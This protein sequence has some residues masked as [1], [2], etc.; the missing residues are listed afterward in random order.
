MSG[1]SYD[2]PLRER[3]T[4][5]TRDAILDALT[6]A[7]NDRAVDEVTT[8]ELAASAGVSERTVYRHFP[9]R[10]ALLEGLTERFMRSSELP[11]AVP[12]HVGEVADL[13][14]ELFRVLEEHHTAAQAEALLNADPRQ[15]SQATRRHT[16]QFR[17]LFEAGFPDLE[18]GRQQSIAAVVR[19]L[20]TSQSWLRMRAE[21][22]VGGEESGPVVAWAIRALIDEVER[23]NP[24]PPSGDQLVR[25]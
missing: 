18:A 11:P 4:Q 2:S 8:K 23:G 16:A 12:E 1:R 19:V 10:T 21:F 22:G 14:V 13:V 6:E 24:P 9:D 3:Q 15:Y 5:Q 17:M 20:A 7:L 25:E